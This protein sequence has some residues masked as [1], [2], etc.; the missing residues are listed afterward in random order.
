MDVE[1]SEVFRSFFDSVG[2]SS[3]TYI[4]EDI[5]TGLGSLDTSNYNHGDDDDNMQ[6]GGNVTVDV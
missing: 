3:P 4:G 6:L 1:E 5:N 2:T